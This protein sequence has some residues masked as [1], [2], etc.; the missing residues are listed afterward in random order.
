MK[1][2]ASPAPEPPFALENFVPYRLSV[3]SN[4]VSGAIAALYR[5]RF[6]LTIPEW[7]CLAV[8]FRYAPL[9]AGEVAAR[10]AM[11][12][13]Q[14]SRAIA[15]LVAKGLALQAIDRS[16]RRRAKLALS[17]AGRRMHDE[18][19]PLARTAEARLLDGL[20]AAECR[21]LDRLFAKL[22]SRAK[23]LA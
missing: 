14:V 11:D 13:V 4:T 2:F 3:L 6:G 21:Q 12:K 7:R 18:I 8:L 10:T 22:E 5:E 19:V 23:L 17:A 9:S 16:D 15:A 20:D 1:P